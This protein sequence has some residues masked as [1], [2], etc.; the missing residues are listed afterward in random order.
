MFVEHAVAVRR[1]ERVVGQL[2]HTRFQG[3]SFTRGTARR[4]AKLPDI[5][6]ILD[7]SLR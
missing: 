3:S 5:V 6:M 4:L 7:I 1:D 2:F